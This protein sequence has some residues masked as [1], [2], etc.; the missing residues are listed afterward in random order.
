MNKWKKTELYIRWVDTCEERRLF[1]Y[2][3]CEIL[4]VRLLLTFRTASQAE[5]CTRKCETTL[6][7]GW[8]CRRRLCRHF[9]AEWNF[10]ICVDQAK[11]VY[12]IEMDE[13]KNLFIDKGRLFISD[14]W[15]FR[16]IVTIIKINIAYATTVCSKHCTTVK[17]IWD[18][19]HEHTC[20]TQSERV[21]NLKFHILLYEVRPSTRQKIRK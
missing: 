3:V 10:F 15:S 19:T 16:I 7:V 9:T 13:W 17:L 2:W 14:L 4:L 1:G 6:S 20:K 5:L 18:R 21:V 12:V 8:C 11:H